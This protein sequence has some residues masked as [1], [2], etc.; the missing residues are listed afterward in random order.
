MEIRAYA[1]PCREETLGAKARNLAGT[2]ENFGERVLE[3]RNV[4]N[5]AVY[6]GKRAVAQS[7][8][9][10]RFATEDALARTEL[11]IRRRPFQSLAV[12]F[13]FGIVIGGAALFAV[14]E[15]RGRA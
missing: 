10:G 7:V 1:K 11:V 3:T 15:V 12:A 14:G 6:E 4:L 8:R 13:A 2:V 9:K 5:N